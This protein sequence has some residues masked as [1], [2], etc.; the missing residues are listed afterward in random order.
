MSYTIYFI[1]IVLKQNLKRINCKKK[2]NLFL[3]SKRCFQKLPE[4][5]HSPLFLPI[6]VGEPNGPRKNI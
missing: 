6:P 4:N 3:V 5:F 2:F 1:K